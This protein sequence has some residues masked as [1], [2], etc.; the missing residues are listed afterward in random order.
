MCQQKNKPFGSMSAKCVT[1]LSNILLKKCTVASLRMTKTWNTDNTNA[2]KDVEPQLLSFTAG[3]N[4][5]WYSH[6]QRQFVSFLLS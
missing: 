5:K 3:G 2:G 4:V 1:C 6:F